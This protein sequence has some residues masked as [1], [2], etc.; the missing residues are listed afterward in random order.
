[1]IVKEDVVKIEERINEYLKDRPSYFVGFKNSMTNL[2]PKTKIGY[3]RIVIRFMDDVKKEPS[4]L[5]YDD[6]TSYISGTEYKEDGTKVTQSFRIVIYSALKKFCKYLYVTQKISQNYMADID[7]PK[8]YETNETKDKRSKGYLTEQE[9]QNFMYLLTEINP[10]NDLNEPWAMRDLAIFSIMVTTG[11]RCSATRNLNLDDLD[12]ENKT[13]KV[14]DKGDKSRV[15]DLSDKVVY[16]LKEY[17]DWTY[18]RLFHGV[19]K[20]NVKNLTDPDS[21]RAL[22]LNDNG[23][24]IV[25]GYIYNRLSYYNGYL[26]EYNAIEK[27]KTLT[28]HKLRATCG[29]QL[30]NKTHDI[31]FV[32]K[33]MGHESPRTTEIYIR[34]DSNI[35]KDGTKI[36]ESLF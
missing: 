27:G 31:Y 35:T 8:F 25:D 28:P 6:F 9:L 24:R 29:T 11:I 20:V 23:E 4:E 32:Q 5:T 16:Y 19:N 17:L 22:F 15:F 18:P 7:R 36:M 30:Y 10:I 33:Y 13:L 12:L 26:H 3:I 2:S 21:Q 14:T 1:M 34:D